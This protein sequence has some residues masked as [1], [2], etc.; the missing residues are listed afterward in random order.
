MAELLPRD[1]KIG[2]SENLFIPPPPLSLS[3]IALEIE[4]TPAATKDVGT[5]PLKLKFLKEP[6]IFPLKHVKNILPFYLKASTG[7]FTVT[8]VFSRHPVLE[9]DSPLMAY[10]RKELD[11]AISLP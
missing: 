10:A 4:K 9:K 8:A 6:L 3:R 11:T 7:P 1:K 5:L 2:T